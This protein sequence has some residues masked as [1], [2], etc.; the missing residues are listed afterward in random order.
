MCFAIGIA[1]LIALAIYGYR[2]TR[3]SVAAADWVRHT[4]EVQAVL[5]GVGE[6]LV[7]GEVAMRDFALTGEKK[8]LAEMETRLAGARACEAKARQITSDNPRQQTR[9]SRLEPLIAEQAKFAGEVV[10]ARQQEGEAAAIALMA[11]G[12]GLEIKA[13]VD[14]LLSE[15]DQEEKA[16][17]IERRKAAEAK[18]A[19]A[20]L[21][22]PIGTL[23][24]IGLLLTAYIFLRSE[25]LDR[26]RI[27]EL[28]RESEASFRLSG[29]TQSS[30]LD[31][32]PAHIALL[33]S[34]AEI[35]AVNEA[36]KR[37]G[38][39][40]LLHSQDFAVGKNYLEV[41]ERAH[42]D[43]S[44]E[45][46][47][48]A[49]GIRSVLHGEEREFSLEYPCHS[50]GEERWFRLMVTPVS[51][52]RREGVVVMH[53]NVTERRLAENR[54]RM[55][56]HTL[57]HIG[58]A[59]IATDTAGVIFYANRAASE[60]YGWP[61]AEI[62]GRS[63]MEVTVPHA[64]REQAD[65]ILRQL[66]QGQNWSGEFLVQSRSGRFFPA[67]VTDS[68]LFDES[69]KL[70]G[71]VGI[72]SDITNRKQVE[73]L[74]RGSEWQQRQL[75][76]QLVAER[77]RLLEAQ[78]VAHLGSWDTDIATL[79][80][81]WSPEMYAIYEQNPESYRPDYKSI[82]KLV[83]PDD[84]ERIDVAFRKAMET[85]GEYAIE[86]RLL[87]PDGRIKHVEERWRTIY[88]AEGKP[89]RATGVCH[90]L[91]ERKVAQ[92]ALRRAD[93]SLRTTLEGMTEAFV[94]VDR[95]WQLTYL[96]A[97]AERLVQQPRAALL[98][99]N[100]WEAFPPLLG[101]VF[102][103][104]YRRAMEENV[105][106]SFE[107]MFAPL[108]L[109][110]EGRV[111]PSSEGLAIYVRDITELHG[112]REALR[113]SEREFH[114]LA[115]SMPQIVWA[116]DTEGRAT[117]LNQ[118]WVD[119]TGFT[120][121]ESLGGG[122]YGAF[123]PEDRQRT[124]EAWARTLAG[125]GE[126][127]VELRIRAADGSSRWF[128][129]RASPQRDE[130]GQVVKWFG[131]CTD[132][133][134]LKMADREI[135]RTNRALKMLSSCNEALIHAEDEGKLLHAVCEVAVNIGGYELA[136]IGYPQED[137][138]GSIKAMAACGEAGGYLERLEISWHEGAPNG[139][140]PA[141]RVLRSGQLVLVRDVTKDPTFTNLDLALEFDF[142]SVTALP[143]RLEGRTFG[144]LFLYAREV[145]ES[146][147]TELKLLQ[148]L[149]DDLAFGIGNL[150]SRNERAKLQN[151]VVKVAGAVS[152]A[153]GA[154]FFEQLARNMAE[155]LDA[156]ASFVAR[157]LPDAERTARTISG[158]ID[159]KAAPSFDFR[160]KDSP[161]FGQA[162]DCMVTDH[163]VEQFPDFLETAAKDAQGFV[164]RWLTNSAGEQI[165]MVFLLFRE[166]H[167][168]TEF[169]SST[170]RIFAAR[171]A[172]ELERERTEMQLREQAALLDAAHEAI[173]VKSLDDGVSYWNKGAE[174]LYGWTAEEVIG[175]KISERLYAN[176]EKIAEAREKV[177]SAGF[178]EGEVE[179]RTK[180]GRIL[181]VKVSWTLMRDDGGR[182][183]S[184]LAINSDITRAQA[185]RA[186]IPP[187]P[188]DGKHR[189]ARRRHRA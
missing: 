105:A 98:G 100:L 155:A 3:D 170:L 129:N 140:G 16:L 118:N 119:Y 23:L 85:R 31:A 58:Q 152:A 32:L 183:R 185:D 135:T 92:E 133:H 158:V 27:E 159:G 117:Y 124:G 142:R 33:D 56:A 136:W 162:D 35:V 106:V 5:R 126:F 60:L 166:P 187:R 22:L 160:I 157:L 15:M 184:I 115:E 7:A 24:S 70:I 88:D 73:E 21:V 64:S 54:L 29:K 11:T 1:L 68:P 181:N 121:E 63:V 57:D 4:H 66:Q 90:D 134:D 12:R 50:P 131:T 138:S 151:I 111:Y 83:H 13:Q 42:G 79:E 87:L 46:A 97:E 168:A 167:Q 148:E 9:L 165:G 67:E 146:T 169:V 72:S 61:L 52:D 82:Q 94:T 71:I 154:E 116:A 153:T 178:W 179:K 176:P 132:I 20:M 2:S 30:I 174:R 26:R 182:P 122:F 19:Q 78:A 164:G 175:E 177:I 125:E 62:A 139:D 53:I 8:L 101:T 108:G 47:A 110:V 114:T 156:Q 28:L 84:L 141:G 96:N 149:A 41:C 59:V 39:A 150:R 107:G 188:A 104:N 65:E 48:A 51:E 18:A 55:Q 77:A 144:A 37:F 189:H 103:T 14:A 93:E 147:E 80:V 112:Q 143:M 172:S 123:H 99:K 95:E 186:A 102:E 69:G 44:N 75:A 36:W 81:T 74:V 163:V 137:E 180:D 89:I 161:C 173:Y 113:A 43:C 91:T 145:S 49:N 120:F 76:Q 86:H 127:A 40:N 6:R 130:H 171:A 17:L 10:A 25:V 34:T 109:W 45:A 38:T 128:L